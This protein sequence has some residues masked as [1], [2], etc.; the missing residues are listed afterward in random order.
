M[1]ERKK[2]LL[3]KMV[4]GGDGC[5]DCESKSLAYSFAL[6]EWHLVPPPYH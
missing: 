6:L 4:P 5:H 2:T 3:E 1:K